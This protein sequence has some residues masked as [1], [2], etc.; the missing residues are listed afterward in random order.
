[1]ANLEFLIQPEIIPKAESLVKSL[2]EEGRSA[3]A[4][5][6]DTL[7]SVVS[8][9]KPNEL[10]TIVQM[11][12]LYQLSSDV[13]LK[14]IDGGKL[15]AVQLQDDLMVLLP[16]ATVAWINEL[17]ALEADLMNTRPPATENEINKALAPGRKD[18]T[19]IGKETK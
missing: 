7:L 10:L 16:S 8:P 5:T 3:E 17:H 9:G 2:R 13:I 4:D 1:M 15:L 14:W 19:W 6:V 11:A 12:E 18:W